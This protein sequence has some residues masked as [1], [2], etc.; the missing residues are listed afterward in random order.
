MC[1]AWLGDRFD[2]G[3]NS[4]WLRRNRVCE[5]WGYGAVPLGL[6]GTEA[7]AYLARR[8]LGFCLP[9]LRHETLATLLLNLDDASLATARA[10]ISAVGRGHWHYTRQDCVRLVQELAGETDRARPIAVPHSESAEVVA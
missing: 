8:G 4:D 5:S 1:V 2:V 3:A 10:R 7:G 9:D 6:A